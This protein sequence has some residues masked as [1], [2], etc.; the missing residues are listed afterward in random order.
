MALIDHLDHLVQIEPGPFGEQHRFRR[1]DV[2]NGDQMI[3]DKLHSAAI[4]VI[5][6]IGTL[7]GK[8]GKQAC[9]PRD[10]GFIAAGVDDEVSNR[11]L[12]AGSAEGAVERNMTCR[13]ENGLETRLVS[14]GER[15]EFDD[16]TRWLNT[17]GN[18]RRNGMGGTGVGQAR[19][20]R[21]CAG[22]DSAC[23]ID[24]GHSGKRKLVPARRFGVESDDGPAALD[25]VARDGAAHDAEA[26]DPHGAICHVTSDLPALGRRL[27][28]RFCANPRKSY[29]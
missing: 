2:V 24:D 26:N 17:P 22:G 29:H 8:V 14:D 16:N 18:F 15:T 21:R 4:T 7:L 1:G 11:G 20:D 3:G 10:S 9:T 5:S 23:T 27:A 28:Q 13:L 6:K 12:G 25:E 19:H